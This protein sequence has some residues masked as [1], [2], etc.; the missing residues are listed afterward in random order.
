MEESLLLKLG[1]NKNEAKVYLK[2]LA[3]GSSTAG[4]LIKATG[5]H[6]NIVYDNL[7]KLV[8]KGLVSFILEGKKKVF[9]SAA[10]EM[11][12]DLLEKEQDEL[13]QKK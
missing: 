13:D 12:S 5:F 2:L 3:H 9:M 1:L 11:I 7:E 8:D 6:R 10:P 4:N